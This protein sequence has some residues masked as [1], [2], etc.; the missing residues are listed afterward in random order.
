[1]AVLDKEIRRFVRDDQPHDALAFHATV[2]EPSRFRRAR[3]VEPNLGLTPRPYQSG[4][5][6]RQGHISKC[7]DRFTRTCLYELPMSFSRRCSGGPLQA[8]GHGWPS[9]LDQEGARCYCPQD[10]CDPALHLGLTAR[11]FGGPRK[12]PQPDPDPSHQ[13]RTRRD[14][15]LAGTAG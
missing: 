5:T 14:A 1:V 10:R 8:W 9:A 7:G 13:L 12:W 3:D 2:D 11:S 6:D 15:V 4:E